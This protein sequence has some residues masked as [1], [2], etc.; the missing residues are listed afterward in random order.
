MGDFNINTEDI[1]NADTIIFS[2][3]M[4]ALCLNQHVTNPT[5]QKGNILGLIFTEEKSD[6][7]ITKH[8]IY[9]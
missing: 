7:Q 5:H 3:T 8:I 6:I 1:S 9:I 4:Q 2:D